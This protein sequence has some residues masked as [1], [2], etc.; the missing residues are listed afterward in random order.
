[1]AGDR[2]DL[3]EGL[4][5]RDAHGLVEVDDPVHGGF[6]ARSRQRSSR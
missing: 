3:V 1:L 5:R 2:A 4:G 6:I